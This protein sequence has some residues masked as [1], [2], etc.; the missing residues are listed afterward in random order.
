MTREE[1]IKAERFCDNNCTWLDHHP[2]CDKAEQP[3]YRAVK[4]WHDGK[5]VYAAAIRARGQT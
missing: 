2:E 5:P 3:A 1:I 4:T